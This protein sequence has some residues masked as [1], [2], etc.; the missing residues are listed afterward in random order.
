MKKT[1]LPH[2]HQQQIDRILD[3][4]PETEYFT[5][6]AEL[7]KQLCDRTRLRIFWLLCH[8]EEC[9]INIAAAVEMTPA[10]VSHHLKN[11]KMS[12][13]I[14]SRRAGK[15]VYY[16]VA[17]NDRARLLHRIAD[18]YFQMTCPGTGM[19]AP[20]AQAPRRGNQDAE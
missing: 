15:E 18:D 13:L 14:T 8:C 6:A 20:A 2:D 1:S 7:F 16:T 11:L 3:R 5:E 10:A 17:G 12:G 4:M 19:A 9:G